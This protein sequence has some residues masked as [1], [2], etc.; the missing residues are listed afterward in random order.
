MSAT[1]DTVV[2]LTNATELSGRL[3]KGNRIAILCLPNMTF[4]IDLFHF[5]YLLFQNLFSSKRSHMHVYRKNK[6]G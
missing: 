3:I 1:Y 6:V 4:M 5:A 2:M